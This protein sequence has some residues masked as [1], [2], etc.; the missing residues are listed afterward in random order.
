[1]TSAAGSVTL[2]VEV[3][4]VR[5]NKEGFQRK[6][7]LQ[8]QLLQVYQRL[9][10]K[11]GPRHWWPAETPFEVIVGAILTQNVAW[12]NVQKAIGN[13]KA[14]EALSAEALLA[15]P[16]AELEEL[17]RP[18]RY[19]KVK[20]RKLKAFCLYL[21]KN[22][23][24]SLEALFARPLPELRKELLGVWG[25]G[26]ETV[27]SILCYAGGKAIMPMDAYTVRIFSRLGLVPE[28]ISYDRLQEFFL[29][30]LPGDNQLFNEYHALLDALGHHICLARKP[31]CSEC[32][33]AE[34]CASAAARVGEETEQAV[35]AAASCHRRGFMLE[36]R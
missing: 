7:G 28:K 36:C 15:L 20:A 29:A 6:E 35:L 2:L 10:E 21:H 4:Q 25:L 17:I 12:R 11:F 18:T 34:L 30:R 8:A 14:R 1:L 5:R 16:A 24:G 31:R 33:L 19:Y 22:Y 23:G 27:D 13:L 32:P 9:W 26:K 3:L